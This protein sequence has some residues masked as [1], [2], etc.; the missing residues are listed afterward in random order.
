[1]PAQRNYPGCKPKAQFSWDWILRILRGTSLPGRAKD[2]KGRDYAYYLC[3][4]AKSICKPSRSIHKDTLENAV[5][6]NLL[7]AVGDC[8]LTKKR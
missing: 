8:G 2:R 1:M 5:F 6:G 3:R 7:S 4:Y